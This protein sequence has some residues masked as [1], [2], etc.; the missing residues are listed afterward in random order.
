MFL[1]SVIQQDDSEVQK[2]L[3]LG[4]DVNYTNSDG[5]SALHQVLALLSS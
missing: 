2:L 3:G 1:D 4:V 5:I